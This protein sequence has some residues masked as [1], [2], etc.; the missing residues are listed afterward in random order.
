MTM[1]CDRGIQQYLGA[2]LLDPDVRCAILDR[3]LA[4]ADRFELSVAERRFLAGIHAAS[5]EDFAV[6]VEQ[7]RDGQLSPGVRSLEWPN[8][9]RRAG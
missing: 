6:L 9:I 3:P 4:L 8:G 2:A 7:W 1:D 5:L